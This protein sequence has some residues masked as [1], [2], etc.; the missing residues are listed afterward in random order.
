[1]KN[2]KLLIAMMACGAVLFGCASQEVDKVEEPKTEQK[3]EVQKPSKV[4]YNDMVEAIQWEMVEDEY[5]DTTVTGKF[6][7]TSDKEIEYIEIEYKFILDGVTVDS[8]WT[9]A[10]NIEP[11]ETIKIEILTFEQFDTMQVKDSEAKEWITVAIES[12]PVEEKIEQQ[13]VTG[14]V[15]IES[16]ENGIWDNEVQYEDFE[17]ANIKLAKVSDDEVLLQYEGT[18]LDYMAD[19]DKEVAG[20]STEFELTSQLLVVGLASLSEPEKTFTLSDSKGTVIYSYIN[21]EPV[22]NGLEDLR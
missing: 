4:T 18:I 11:G 9:N 17:T 6:T 5:G 2:G 12:Q 8:S 1:M 19:V 21:G 20:E 13:D 22:A 7:N 10:I 15:V 3:V 14:P 16:E